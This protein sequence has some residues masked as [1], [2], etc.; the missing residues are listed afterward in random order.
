[1]TPAAMTDQ[2]LHLRKSLQIDINKGRLKNFS[3]VKKSFFRANSKAREFNKSKSSKKNNESSK[4]DG[5]KMQIDKKL[6]RKPSF[7]SHSSTQALISGDTTKQQRSRRLSNRVLQG[8]RRTKS[9][10]WN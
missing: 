2:M 4:G 5:N 8:I 6:L 7:D 3:F 1:M 9:Y 10:H